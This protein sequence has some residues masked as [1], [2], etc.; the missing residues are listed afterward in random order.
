MTAEEGRRTDW[1]KWAKWGSIGFVALLV[2]TVL[3]QNN[4]NQ[5]FRLLLWE[6]GLPPSMLILC[7]FGLGVALGAIALHMLRRRRG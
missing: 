4:K 5:P 7:S 3:I 6:P 1:A 2:L